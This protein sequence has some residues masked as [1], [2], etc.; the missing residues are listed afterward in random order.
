MT[1]VTI[2]SSMVM[3]AD[4]VVL[5]GA[6]DIVLE[7]LISNVITVSCY[8]CTV[9]CLVLVV[10]TDVSPTSHPLICHT[11]TIVLLPPTGYT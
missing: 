7:K 5:I 10:F 9:D 4:V 11:V 6:T 3:L 1:L 2:L 8:Y